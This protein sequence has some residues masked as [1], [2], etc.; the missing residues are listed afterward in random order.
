MG[1]RHGTGSGKALEFV[2]LGRVVLGIVH[3][4]VRVGAAAVVDD[5]EGTFD[6]EFCASVVIGINGEG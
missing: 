3:H 5:K 1:N 2:D 6:L 4:R